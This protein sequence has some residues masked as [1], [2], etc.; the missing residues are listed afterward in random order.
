VAFVAALFLA[1]LLGSI[2]PESF[3]SIEP[4]TH[5]ALEI[6]AAV[7]RGDIVIS[8]CSLK[9]RAADFMRYFEK[10]DLLKATS[11]DAGL[12]PGTLSP[13]GEPGPGERTETMSEPADPVR[14]SLMAGRALDLVDSLLTAAERNGRAVFVVLTPLSRDS[15]RASVYRELTRAIIQHFVSSEP[16]PVRGGVDMIR[17]R[18]R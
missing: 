9:R 1:N 14:T 15:H 17:L 12:S 3:A 5:A 16:V 8:D 2:R 4:D 6:D 7:Q 10:I 13:P 18:R 11:V